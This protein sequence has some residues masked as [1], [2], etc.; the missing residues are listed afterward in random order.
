VRGAKQACQ[1]SAQLD[2]VLSCERAGRSESQQLMA[3][4]DTR[5]RTWRRDAAER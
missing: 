5:E 3:A 4:I 2:R 1:R